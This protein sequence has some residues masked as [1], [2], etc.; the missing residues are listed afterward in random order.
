MNGQPSYD[1]D[2]QDVGSDNQESAQNP[3]LARL[4]W[5]NAPDRHPNRSGVRRGLKVAYDEAPRDAARAVEHRASGN[6]EHSFPLA[7]VHKLV[8]LNQRETPALL[9]QPHYS[10][11]MPLEQPSLQH[12]PP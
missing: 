9:T 2:H 10:P 4:P 1:A 6:R 11:D 3:H 5:L 12:T 8:S 7:V